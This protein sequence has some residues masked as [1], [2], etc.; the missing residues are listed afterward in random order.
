MKSV[1]N[2]LGIVVL[3]VILSSCKDSAL[4]YSNSLRSQS[5]VQANTDSRYDFLWVVDNSG[6]MK[7]RR[8]FIRDNLNGFLN[9]L[10][11]RKAIDYQMAVVTTDYFTDSGSLVKSASGLEVVKSSVSANPIADF[12]E[13]MNSVKDSN[14]SFWEQGLENSY[15]AIFK[16]GS[17]FMRSGVPLI[18]VYLTDEQDFSCKERCWGVQPE[19]NPDWVAHDVGRY[20]EFFKTVKSSEGTEVV[21]FPIVGLDQEK[22]VISSVG[23]R[24]QQVADQVGLYGKSGSICD[25]ELEKSYNNIAQVVA[26]R[27]NVFKL[28]TPASGRNIRVYVDGQLVPADSV[29]Y[30]FDSEQ[31]SIVFKGALPKAGSDIEVTFEEMSK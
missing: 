26:D 12:A 27:G 29:N 28:D 4:F 20:V 10:S 2:F 1:F 21:L 23:E 24:Y 9:T 17:K 5:F 8:D 7:P 14:T 13:L 3:S 22:C 15:Q 18:V 31:N 11:S 16:H 6:S 30:I 25:T 19:N